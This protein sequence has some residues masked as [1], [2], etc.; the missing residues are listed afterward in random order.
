MKNK[1]VTYLLGAVVLIVWGLIIY[2]V[3]D[4]A[5][6]GDDPVA[7]APTA[8][9][10]E[11][12]NDFAMPKDTS[13]LLLNYRD[14]FGLVAQ[15]DTAEIPVKRLVRKSTGPIAVKP[16]M[17]WGFIQYSGYIRNPVSKKLI[18]LVVINGQNQTLTKGEVKDQVK[19]IRNLHDSIKISYQGKIKYITIKPPAL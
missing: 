5:S 16:A 3:F 7:S 12:Y 17:N 14:P 11:V 4:A 2:R 13:R 19:L 9:K 8:I 15:K 6:G 1:K 10:K 18:T